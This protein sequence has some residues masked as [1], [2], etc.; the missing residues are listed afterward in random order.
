MK[1]ST[2]FHF[3]KFKYIF[4]G[5]IYPGA[6]LIRGEQKLVYFNEINQYQIQSM[7]I[8]NTF[9]DVSFHGFQK[10]NCNSRI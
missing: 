9:A 6:I 3:K 8:R 1:L 2:F 4:K 7:W 5:R 10:V